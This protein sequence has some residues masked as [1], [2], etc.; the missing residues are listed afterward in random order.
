MTPILPNYRRLLCMFSW[1]AQNLMG[2]IT[3]F[4]RIS[5][6]FCTSLWSYSMLK[7]ISNYD[8]TI[9][10]YFIFNNVHQ[11][12]SSWHIHIDRPE[13]CK[14]ICISCYLSEHLPSLYTM[15]LMKSAHYEA[16]SL[17]FAGCYMQANLCS[18]QF[19]P[20]HCVTNNT[21]TTVRVW[22]CI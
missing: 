10:C 22:C 13:T 4:Y 3:L 18:Y 12:L 21:I 5:Y 16:A 6:P 19:V 7:S 14:L 2:S 15:R 9:D 1:V 17:S 8:I 11:L 20:F